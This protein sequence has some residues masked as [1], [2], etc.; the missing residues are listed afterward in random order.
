MSRPRCCGYGMRYLGT[1]GDFDAWACTECKRQTATVI[2]YAPARHAEP[3]L[4][5]WVAYINGMPYPGIL[6]EDRSGVDRILKALLKCR[7]LPRNVSVFLDPD[8]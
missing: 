5:Q 1:S 6:A 7:A 4:L 2:R 8:L 3:V